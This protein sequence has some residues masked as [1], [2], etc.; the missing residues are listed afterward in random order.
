[1]PLSQPSLKVWWGWASQNRKQPCS[2]QLPATRT[3]RRNGWVEWEEGE[4]VPQMSAPW[5][6]SLKGVER[7]RY[8][9]STTSVGNPSKPR[10]LARVPSDCLLGSWYPCCK[11]GPPRVEFFE[12]CSSAFV[13]VPQLKQEIIRNRN[14]TF[15]ISRLFGWRLAVSFEAP[16]ITWVIQRDSENLASH[17]PC[18]RKRPAPQAQKESETAPNTSV[19]WAFLLILIQLCILVPLPSSV[20]GCSN[21][22]Q[23]YSKQAQHQASVWVYMCKQQKHI[24]AYQNITDLWEMNL[25]DAAPSVCGDFLASGPHVKLRCIRSTLVAGGHTSIV[26]ILAQAAKSTFSWALLCSIAS[27]STGVAFNSSEGIPQLGLWAF[28]CQLKGR[29]LGMIQTNTCRTRQQDV[30]VEKPVDVLQSRFWYDP[31]AHF[32]HILVSPD[33]TEARPGVQVP[34]S[35]ASDFD[36]TKFCCKSTRPLP[37]EQVVFFGIQVSQSCRFAVAQLQLAAK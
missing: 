26:G 12:I 8:L 4:H 37:L 32:E 34:H 18:H 33:F 22:S 27:K 24:K 25:Q 5:L 11:P 21:M 19:L 16:W 7:Q 31:A 28:K 3:P 23:G 30:F 14:R 36:T 15:Q 1:M 29:S 2:L 20:A 17:V 6:L 9:A 13:P 35:T 10:N